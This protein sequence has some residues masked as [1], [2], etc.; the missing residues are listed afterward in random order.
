MLVKLCGCISKKSNISILI[1]LKKTQL[2]MNQKPQY[3]TK[4]IEPIEEKVR[5]SLELIGTSKDCLSRIPLAQALSSTINKWDLMEIYE[6]K[7]LL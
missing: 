2:Q 7:N 3:R 1:T 4:H 6:I 5:N